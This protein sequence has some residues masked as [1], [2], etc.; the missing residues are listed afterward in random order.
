[1]DSKAY[2]ELLRLIDSWVTSIW[3]KEM[4]RE[5]KKSLILKESVLAYSFYFH[6]R[7]KVENS[8]KYKKHLYI[9]SE[10]PFKSKGDR[11]FTSDLVILIWDEDTPDP[12]E[13]L[14]VLEFK[15]YD[16]SHPY[17]GGIG[18]D[19]E[20]LA[21][22]KKGVYYRWGDKKLKK[23]LKAK[24]AYFLYLVDEGDIKFC[25]DFELRKKALQEDGYCKFLFGYG[26]QGRFTRDS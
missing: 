8:N 1:M 22:L 6:L 15:H 13:I 21:A 12:Q 2:G 23:L 3:E 24:K 17:A 25:P 4:K 5:Y 10:M 14:S 20:N 26:E 9:Y 7:K 11:N 18:K 19:F 16:V